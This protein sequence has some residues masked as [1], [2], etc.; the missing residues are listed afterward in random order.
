MFSIAYLLWFFDGASHFLANIAS[1]VVWLL[2]TAILWVG[3]FDFG[4]Y[5]S[6]DWDVQGTG[7]GIMHGT[8]TGGN[9]K[10]TP[11]LSKCRQSLTVEA[12]GWTEFGLLACTLLMTLFWV[13]MSTLA[14]KNIKD[15]ED[16][17]S[18]SQCVV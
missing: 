6:L 15:A 18:D 7:A 11:T 17:A 3:L 16:R 12:L 2:A 14:R 10:G 4:R 5:T 8:R 9:C 1:S 13:C